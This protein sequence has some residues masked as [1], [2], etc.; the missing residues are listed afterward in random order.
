MRI[1]SASVHNFS[2]Y[3]ELSFDYTAQGLT[4]ISGPTGSGKSTLCD[5]APWILFGVTSKGGTVDEVRSWNADE[6]TTG[7]ISIELSDKSIIEVTRTR[8]S[9]KENDLYYSVD[10]AAGVRGKD[11]RD[12]Q[13]ML[14][15]HLEI[16]SQ[17]YLAGAYFHEFSQTAQFFTAPAKQRRQLTEQLVDLRLAITLTDKI[18]FFKKE[19]SSNKESR[20]YNLTRLKDKISYL[21]KSLAMEDELE[22]KWDDRW[23]ERL[24]ELSLLQGNF[25]KDKNQRIQDIRIE[26]TK[27]TIELQYD[28]AQIEVQPDTH[29]SEINVIQAELDKPT[30]QC[31]GCG[32]P[33]DSAKRA[34]YTKRLYELNQEISENTNRNILQTRLSQSLEKHLQTLEPLLLVETSRINTYAAQ[35][36]ALNKEVNPHSATINI[37]SAQIQE[38]EELIIKLEKELQ[39]ISV[40]LADLETLQDITGIFRATLI[41]QMIVELETS[42]NEMLSKH[43]DAEIRVLFDIADSDK[44]EITIMKD[45]NQ[46][47][48]TQLS[49]GQ[50]Q[51]LKL[52]FSLSVMRSVANY[53]GVSF[54]AIFLDEFVEGLD[55]VLKIKAYGLLQELSTQ[56]ESVFCIDH[57]EALKSMF[58]NR[59]EVALI[60]GESQ[61]EEA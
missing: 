8:G 25:E 56:Y 28:I 34:L 48:Y 3:K 35:V 52:T 36:T 2:S 50:R 44:L 1:L 60:N 16:D 9:S 49:K 55:D 54:N 12:T 13:D 32:N 24:N 14:N 43:F 29:Y 23:I 26:H 38:A 57:N 40:E 6:P 17:M 22:G 4:L 18:S 15:N 5:I 20:T 59:Y 11:I 58:D 46:C 37:Y 19:L 31:P 39:D 47:S 27:K 51:L 61:I 45:G 7:T 42:T 21:E 41:K 10:C 53:N 33:L 30:E